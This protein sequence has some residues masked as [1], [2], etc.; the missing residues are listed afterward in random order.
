MSEPLPAVPDLGPMPVQLRIWL[1][2]LYF[3]EPLESIANHAVTLEFAGFYKAAEAFKVRAFQI[4]PSPPFP[5][6]PE[7]WGRTMDTEEAL[8]TMRALEHEEDPRRLGELALLHERKGHRN[9]SHAFAIRALLI[10][11]VLHS[12]QKP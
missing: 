9:A 8:Q 3:R 2:S 5:A 6:L 12:I 11:A 10:N 4:D 1:Q 7:R